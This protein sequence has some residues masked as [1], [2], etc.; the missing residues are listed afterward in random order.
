VRVAEALTSPTLAETIRVERQ[1]TDAERVQACRR[2]VR[3]A[4]LAVSPSELAMV[5]GTRYELSSLSIVAVDEA[6]ESVA[7]VPVIVEAEE[8]APSRVQLRSDDPDVAE[9]RLLALEPGEFHLRVRT[10]CPIGP[11]AE[12]IVRGRVT[13]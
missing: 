12:R 2:P 4:R 1:F 11:T 9:G 5:S 6:G 3:I 13:R 10:M 7:A 8:T